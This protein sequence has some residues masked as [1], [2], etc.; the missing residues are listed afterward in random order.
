MDKSKLQLAAAF[1]LPHIGAFVNGRI[2]RANLKT[3]YNQINKPKWNPPDYVFAP[4][5][6]TLYSGM[7]YASYLVYRNANMISADRVQLALLLYG[8]QLIL[9]WAWTPLFFKYHSLKWVKKSRF[10][11]F[12]H[13][14]F[15]A[16]F[17]CSA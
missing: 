16:A 8:N 4:V 17:P 5:W 9:N 2:T 10:H 6:L 12:Y 14:I 13:L 7:G 11:S 15:Q 3:W 1:V